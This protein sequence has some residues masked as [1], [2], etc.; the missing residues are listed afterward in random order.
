LVIKGLG[1]LSKVVNIHDVSFDVWWECG[2]LLI[3]IKTS[4]VGKGIKNKTVGFNSC[5][6]V[7]A[8]SPFCV[9]DERG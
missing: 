2:E 4:A 3:Q 6:F 9:R 5:T 7:P 1:K 8:G